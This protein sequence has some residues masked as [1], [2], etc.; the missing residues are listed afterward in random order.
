M[1]RVAA[2]EVVARLFPS[3]VLVV[4]Q[5]AARSTRVAEE[6]GLWSMGVSDEV[7]SQMNQVARAAPRR[8][9]E[10]IRSRTLT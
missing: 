1:V 8:V 2:D 6:D 3:L 4:A 5:L 9:K 10:Q 7:A